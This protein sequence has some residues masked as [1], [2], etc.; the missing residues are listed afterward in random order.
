VLRIV[1][2]LKSSSP[3]PGSSPRCLGPVA[4]TLTTPPPP[5]RLEVQGNHILKVADQYSNTVY[6]KEVAYIHEQVRDIE[7]TVEMVTG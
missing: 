3:W 6:E 2:A 7:P 5:R 1:I 4:S